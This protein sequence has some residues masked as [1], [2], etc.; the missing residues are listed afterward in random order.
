LALFATLLAA[1][2]V[3][4]KEVTP[5]PGASWK[6]AASWIVPK[7][8]NHSERLGSFIVQR[9]SKDSALTARLV[10]RAEGDRAHVSMLAADVA[11]IHTRLSEA[12]VV[13]HC[14]MHS[15]PDRVSPPSAEDVREF[16][17]ET[18]LLKQTHPQVIH[19]MSV[20]DR[21]GVWFVREFMTEAE[22]AGM[23]RNERGVK[24]EAGTQH[25]ER[26][27]GLWQRR[28]FQDAHTSV[29]AVR[30][31]P[32]FTLLRSAFAEAGVYVTYI[33]HDAALKDPC[34]MRTLYTLDR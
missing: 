9:R 6:E 5:K 13:A 31:S 17:K 3:S 16:K 29:D 15:H 25:V 21:V 7:S 33:T 1:G 19:I 10:F 11:S 8:N 28:N 2:A 20:A 12:G 34:G 26:V 22:Q 32:E 23:L 27:V 14:D 24:K 30:T 4:A 18:Q